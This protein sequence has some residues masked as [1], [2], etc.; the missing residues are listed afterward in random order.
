MRVAVLGEPA[1]WHVGRL[2]AALT[3]R[4]HLPAIVRWA[5]IG[6]GIG[7][8]T[9]P[10]PIA[11]DDPLESFGPTALAAADAILVRG[12]P[13]TAGPEDRLEEVVFRMD[14]LGRIAARGTRIINSPRSLEFAIDK[15]LSLARLAAAGLPVPRTLI[16][17]DVTRIADAREQFG[18][19][20]VV[21]PLFGSRGRGLH[22]LDSRG[23][24]AAWLDLPDI[25]QRPGQVVYVQEFIRHE[26]WDARLFVLG[27]QVYAMRRRAAPGDWRTNVARGGHPE[28]FEPP[29]G[30]I[31]LAR[32]AAAALETEIAGIDLVPTPDGSPVILEVNAVPGWRAL[33]GVIGVDIAAEVVRLLETTAG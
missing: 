8:A 24:V 19:D 5:E 15:Y 28:P 6:A 1:G 21:K 33:E 10:G 23:A 32:R 14:A 26:G 25:R 27:P 18:G 3:A 30:W 22:R 16:V 2:T 12:M 9:C 11:P 20:C 13:G 31:S 29:H 7:T 4:G 17:Q